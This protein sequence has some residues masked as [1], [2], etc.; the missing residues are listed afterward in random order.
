MVMLSVPNGISEQCSFNATTHNSLTSDNYG[1][2]PMESTI[3]LNISAVTGSLCTFGHANLY[4]SPASGHPHQWCIPPQMANQPPDA[5][6][7]VHALPP[8]LQLMTQYGPLCHGIWSALP[9]SMVRSAMEYGLLCHG[10][11]DSPKRWRWSGRWIY[12]IGNTGM[13]CLA[14][15]H[16]FHLLTEG[17][18]VLLSCAVSST[19]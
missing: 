9:W 17:T 16:S 6:R 8:Q 3:A 7:S 14:S 5:A 11:T 10:S 19:A 2:C 1:S 15:A 18:Q 12:C 13:P 4:P